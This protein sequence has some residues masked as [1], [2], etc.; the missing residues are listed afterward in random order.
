MVVRCD[1]REHRVLVSP[2][3]RDWG[4]GNAIATQSISQRCTTGRLNVGRTMKVLPTALRGVL[5][6]E[7]APFVDQRGAFARWYCETEQRRHADRQMA[8]FP[9]LVHHAMR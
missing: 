9:Q 7:T 5:V 6:V 2:F 8:L 3:S 4:R 1:P